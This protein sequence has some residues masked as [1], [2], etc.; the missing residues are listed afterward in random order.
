MPC[1]VGGSERDASVSRRT[2]TDGKHARERAS[3]AET[4]RSDI[5]ANARIIIVER[6]LPLCLLASRE[7]ARWIQEEMAAVVREGIA[8]KFYNVY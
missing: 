2:C 1:R 8:R 5:I 4:F 7:R 6:N 3:G